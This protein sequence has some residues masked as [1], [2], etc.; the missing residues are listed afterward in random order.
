MSSPVDHQR[1]R[2]TSKKDTPCHFIS[3][4]IGRICS[5]EAARI[6]ISSAICSFCLFQAGLPHSFL[7]RLLR[8]EPT[9]GD[10]KMI[11]T[12]AGLVNPL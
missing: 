6:P 5:R 4:S 11:C 12:L 1:L 9:I 3:P 7:S 2:L 10:I 8:S